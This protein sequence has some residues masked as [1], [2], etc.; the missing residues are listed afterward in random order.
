MVLSP[1]LTFSQE[2][3][4]LT[5][6]IVTEFEQYNLGDKFWIGKIIAH[7]NL[8]ISTPPMAPI[9]LCLISNMK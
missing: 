8:A 6:E 1:L 3:A 7:G 4:W 5:K 2:Q 9:S